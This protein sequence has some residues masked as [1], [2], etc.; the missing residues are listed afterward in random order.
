M[1]HKLK[2]I[3][4]AFLFCLLLSCKDNS[5]KKDISTIDE[6]ISPGLIFTQTDDLEEAAE[7]FKSYVNTDRTLEI[8]TEINHVQNAKDVNLELGFNQVFFIDNPRYSVPLID[9]N[10]LMALEFPI[11]IGF[12]QIENEKF[13]VA[14]SEDYFLKRYRLANS[15][16][17]RSVGTLSETFLKQSSNAAYT[18]NSPIDSLD[19]NGIRTIKSP[20]NYEETVSSIEKLIE[21][22]ED[23]SLFESKDFAKDAKNIGAELK[24]LHLFVFGN[25]KVGTQLMQQ[26]PNFSIDL[27]LR[28]LIEKTENKNEEEGKEDGVLIHFQDLS[29]TAKLHSEEFD[30]NLPGQITDKL[31]KMLNQAIS[32]EEE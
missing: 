20:K 17:L 7:N 25:P 5:E 15:A 32:K 21:S 26:N 28:V 1:K 4:P 14:R 23:L 22:N 24:P 9:E 29:F 30:G 27:P 6:N 8:S 3:L 18:Q 12:F 19:N 31:E 11:R 13:I 2:F 16:A 10:P